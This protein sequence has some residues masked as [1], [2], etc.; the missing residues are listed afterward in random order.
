MQFKKNTLTMAV[1]SAL[2]AASTTAG[3]ASTADL[4]KKLMQLEAEMAALRQE[5][6]AT[7]ASEP[8]QTQQV[9]SLENRVT[10]VETPVKTLEERVAKVEAAPAMQAKQPG[11]MIFFRGGFAQLTDDRGGGAFT[12][13]YGANALLGGAPDTLNDEDSGWY[14]GAGFDFELSR[15][16]WGLLPTVGVDAELMVEF[17]HISSGTTWLVVPSAECALALDALTGTPGNLAGC[18]IV[19]DNN[20]SQ[21]T[22]SAS[23]KLK[24]M[25]GS[26][27]QPWLIPVGLDFRVISPPSDSSAYLDVG[28][29]FAGGAEYEII[30]GIKLGADIRYHLAAGLTNPDYNMSQATIQALQAAGLKFN[31]PSNDYWTAGAYLGIGF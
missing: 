14:A 26:K 28:A 5:L 27:F 20:I 12:D 10:A 29:Q 17:S 19:G 7:Q 22:V 24:F 15:D 9:Q 2:L 11:N 1:V 25:Q 6:K 23:P 21:L 30:P 3:A 13:I 16:T 8:A 31:E 18:G 4:E